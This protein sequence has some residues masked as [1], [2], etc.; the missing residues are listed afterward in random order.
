MEGF[1]TIQGS[2][3]RSSPAAPTAQQQGATAWG[4]A[5]DS[6]TTTTTDASTSEP[7]VPATGGPRLI[8]ESE[9]GHRF[10]LTYQDLILAITL[11]GLGLA[12]LSAW[13]ST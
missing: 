3:A 8:I 11:G 5:A 12:T 2:G 4:S 6:W 7:A 9:A 1:A 13:R 10:V